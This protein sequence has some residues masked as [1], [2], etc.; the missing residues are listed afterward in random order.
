MKKTLISLA[1][2]A[3][4][5]G[6]PALAQGGGGG[7]ST[8]NPAPNARVLQPAEAGYPSTSQLNSR[9]QTAAGT[10]YSDESISP[11]NPTMQ[12]VLFGGVCLL[13]LLTIGMLTKTLNDYNRYPHYAS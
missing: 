8:S 4:L 9:T 10:D 7:P 1:V 2:L 6:A 13:G 11:G 3:S 5:G 12:Y